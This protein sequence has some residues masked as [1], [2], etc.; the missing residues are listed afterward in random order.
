M[1]NELLKLDTFRGPHSTGILRVHKGSNECAVLKDVGT[2]WELEYHPKY[3]S[4]IETG[5]SRI[6]LGHNRYATKGNIIAQN[7]HPFVAGSIIGAHN[8]TLRNQSLLTD[9]KFFEVDSENIFNEMS[10]SG[11]D[12]TIPKLCGAFALTFYNKD[13]TELSFIRNSERTL[14]YTYSEDGKTLFWASEAGMLQYIFHRAAKKHT[15][16]LQFEPLRWYRVAIPTNANDIGKFTV[17][18]VTAYTYPVYNYNNRRAWEDAD[19]ENEYGY[20]YP[21]K[22]TKPDGYWINNVWYPRHNNIKGKDIINQP[23]PLPKPIESSV[24]KSKLNT[25]IE[26]NVLRTIVGS[27]KNDSYV[28][29][30]TMDGEKVRAYV[31]HGSER[32]EKYAHVGIVLQGFVKEKRYNQDEKRSYNLIKLSTLAL[33]PSVQENPPEEVVE[34]EEK[35]SEHN[36][37]STKGKRQLFTFGCEA[38]LGVCGRSAY[39]EKISGGCG[40]CGDMLDADADFEDIEWLSH[41]QPICGQCAADMVSL[42]SSIKEVEVIEPVNPNNIMH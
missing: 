38:P 6:L 37:F 14:F 26:F 33:A 11:V 8:G 23:L 25:L 15:D 32:W 18:P 35:K 16:I 21:Q 39:I 13:T 10:I 28:E 17:K 31:P 36:S 30:N 1:F 19:P 34:V 42:S 3:K 20:H 24:I 7:A 27:G 29:G 41:N 9:H 22:E 2:P 12:A 40:I 4:M 5:W